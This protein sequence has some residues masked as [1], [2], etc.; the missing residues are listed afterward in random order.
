MLRV[1]NSHGLD[2]TFVHAAVACLC[3]PSLI[4]LFAAQLVHGN[5]T[6]HATREHS[7]AVS[8]AD[9]IQTIRVVTAHTLRQGVCSSV[10]ELELTVR[11]A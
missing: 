1:V 8:A 6:I 5:A 4:A 2:V 10:P 11:V 3:P 7:G 9:K